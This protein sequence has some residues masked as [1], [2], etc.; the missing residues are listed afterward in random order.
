M[1]VTKHPHRY[2]LNMSHSE[3]DALRRVISAGMLLLEGEDGDGLWSTFSPGE[4]MVIGRWQRRDPTQPTG[5]R[6]VRKR[7]KRQPLKAPL[8]SVA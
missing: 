1:F 3:M 5:P 4:R 6:S 2:L 7:R 8:S